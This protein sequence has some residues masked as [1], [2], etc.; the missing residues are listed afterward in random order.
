MINMRSLQFTLFVL[1]IQNINS[2]IEFLLNF[3]LIP[4]AFA[5]DFQRHRCFFPHHLITRL[6]PS[7]TLA[8]GH[9]VEI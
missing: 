1:A 2:I 9:D 5:Q 3:V 8:D 6:G 7:L 4:I